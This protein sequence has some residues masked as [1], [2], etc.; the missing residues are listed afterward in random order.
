[1]NMLTAQD[2]LKVLL[3]Y[4]SKTTE[5]IA[6]AFAMLNAH[7]SLFPFETTRIRQTDSGLS[8]PLPPSLSPTDASGRWSLSILH[9]SISFLSN[10]GSGAF[11]ASPDRTRFCGDSQTYRP[12]TPTRNAILSRWRLVVLW[13]LKGSC[14]TIRVFFFFFL[15]ICKILWMA[16][17]SLLLKLPLCWALQYT[18]WSFNPLFSFVLRDFKP[19]S[20]LSKFE[21]SLLRVWFCVS[22]L[23]IS[24]DRFADT[25]IYR[26]YYADET[27]SLKREKERKKS[28]RTSKLHWTTNQTNKKPWEE[29]AHDFPPNDSL[30]PSWWKPPQETSQSESEDKMPRRLN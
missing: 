2:M 28:N 11:L 24:W 18:G 8:P 19:R 9:M 27:I 23:T 17:G 15:P 30:K 21:V 3:F 4:F 10:V 6:S 1:M 25:I 16:D 7:N 20:A 22:K 26:F 14:Y 13:D 12:V 29:I 5:N